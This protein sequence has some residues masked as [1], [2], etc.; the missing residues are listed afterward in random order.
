MIQR[1]IS[2]KRRLELEALRLAGS[3]ARVIYY[4]GEM[5]LRPELQAEGERVLSTDA[6]EEVIRA[7]LQGEEP[8]LAEGSTYWRLM[9]NNGNVVMQGN[10]K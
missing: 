10:G 8:K 6:P 7:M 1:S 4:H 9:D 2:L 5:P 3:L